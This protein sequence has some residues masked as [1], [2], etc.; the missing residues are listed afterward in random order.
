MELANRTLRVHQVQRKLCFTRE[1]IHLKAPHG[2]GGATFIGHAPYFG[3]QACGARKRP[4]R[5]DWNTQHKAQRR[6]ALR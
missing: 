6:A 4:T 2:G 5:H 3:A 1:Q